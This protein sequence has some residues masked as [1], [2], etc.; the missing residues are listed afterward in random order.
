MKLLASNLSE[1]EVHAP[2]M[3]HYRSNVRD[4]EFNLFEVLDRSSILGTA[5]YEDLDRETVSAILA[6]ADHLARTKLA[7]TFAIGEHEAPVFDPATRSVTL[8][9]AFKKS[10]QALMD[11]GAWA[12]E[13]PAE[14]GGHVTP[15]SVQWAVNEL[16]MGANPAAYLYS[17]GPKFAY[18]VWAHGTERD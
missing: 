12:L 15:H 11:S 2:T 16:N 6:E 5:P 18:A 4:I 3:S 13:L 9:E 14:L 1:G 8:P 7:E 10:F 17:A